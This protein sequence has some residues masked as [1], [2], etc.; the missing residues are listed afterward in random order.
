MLY[1]DRVG[2]IGHLV[3]KY[4]FSQ[5][6]KMPILYSRNRNGWG[7]QRTRE[8]YDIEK[9]GATEMILSMMLCHALKNERYNESK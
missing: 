3:P 2:E 8:R 4:P 6:A 5:Q 1:S 9:S 7:Q